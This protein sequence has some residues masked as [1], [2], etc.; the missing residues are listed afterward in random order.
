[1]LPKCMRSGENVSQ[2]FWLGGVQGKR[3]SKLVSVS[4]KSTKET[5]HGIASYAVVRIIFLNFVEFCQNG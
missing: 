4:A 1:M 5:I 3:K 2:H